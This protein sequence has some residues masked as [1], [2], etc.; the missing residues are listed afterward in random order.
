MNRQLKYYIS[1]EPDFFQESEGEFGVKIIK[2]IGN[3]HQ[4]SGNCP[5]RPRHDIGNEMVGC[6][7]EGS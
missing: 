1:I 5:F 2:K 4:N 6:R 3:F 7:R